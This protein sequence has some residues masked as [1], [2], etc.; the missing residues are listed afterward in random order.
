MRDERVVAAALALAEAEREC[1]EISDEIQRILD[2]GTLA[3]AH[4]FHRQR[5]ICGS[6]D[7]LAKAYRRAYDEAK[8]GK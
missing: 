1:A 8:G 4:L 2:T 7:G 3:P 5:A 6:R